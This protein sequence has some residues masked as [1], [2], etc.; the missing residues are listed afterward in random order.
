MEFYRKSNV[1]LCL[2]VMLSLSV[3]CGASAAEAPRHM[4]FVSDPQYPWSDLTDAD[5]LD[6]D[7]E[8]R[9]KE[10]IELQYSDIASFR[11]LNGGASHIPVMV[12]GDVT[13]FGHAGERSYMKSVF[14]NKLQRLYDYGLGNHD[15]ANN[16][17]DCF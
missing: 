4:V 15:Y 13:A 6:P 5:V 17:D 10:L 11:K 7:K 12:N 1:L 2:A 16:I 14:D 8:A 9:S 3:A